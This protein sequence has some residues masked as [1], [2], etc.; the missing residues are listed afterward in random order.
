MQ[1]VKS[2]WTCT[3]QF[4]FPFSTNTS[5][6]VSL[7]WPAC[8]VTKAQLLP[9]SG[10]QTRAQA[11][12]S[13]ILVAAPLNA[14]ISA[15]CRCIFQPLFLLTNGQLCGTSAFFRGLFFASFAALLFAPLSIEGVAFG[16]VLAAPFLS[17]FPP[18]QTQHS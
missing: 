6:L 8:T 4:A 10:G 15:E 1:R 5:V 3:V 18:G 12:H 17:L 7:S 11:R 9:P 16:Q 2:S 14:D 13:A